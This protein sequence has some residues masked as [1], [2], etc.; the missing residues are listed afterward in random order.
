VTW[1]LAGPAAETLDLATG[2]AGPAVEG[3]AIT[4]ELGAYE[5]RRLR[6]R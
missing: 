4:V 2:R 5:V 6:V 1:T 3:G